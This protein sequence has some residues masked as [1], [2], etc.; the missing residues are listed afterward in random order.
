M[1]CVSRVVPRQRSSRLSA[2][3][4][5]RQIG[6]DLFVLLAR[7][8]VKS[9]ISRAI[10]RGEIRK[11]TLLGKRLLGMMFLPVSLFVFNIRYHFFT[12]FVMFRRPL[13]RR[14]CRNV[15]SAR[16]PTQLRSIDNGSDRR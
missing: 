4:I 16:R 13:A 3:V 14:T 6:F 15:R 5:K 1:S 7:I 2:F 11:R 8:F 10:S 12:P 9:F